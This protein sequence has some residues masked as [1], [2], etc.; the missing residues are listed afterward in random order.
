MTQASLHNTISSLPEPDEQ[1]MK[2]SS[3]LSDSIKSLIEKNSGSI[4][5][6]RYMQACLYEPGLGY[7]SA[8]SR[9]FGAAG[10]FITAPE[11]S[12]LFSR[13]LAA[14]CVQVLNDQSSGVILEVGAGSGRMACDILLEMEQQNILPEEYW[15][16]EVSADLIERQK[17][18]V[19]E[20]IPQHL[21]RIKW[22]DK[23]PIEKFNGIIL[24]N[25]VVD[26]LPIRRFNKV[27]NIF[28]ELK[29]KHYGDRFGWTSDQADK[30]LVSAIELL[31][32]KYGPWPENYYSEINLLLDG[33]VKSFSDIIKKGLM[34]IIDYG[35]PGSDYYHTEREDGTLLCHY[36][37]HAHSDPFLYPGLQDIS[38]SVN[39]TALAESADSNGL[40]VCGYTTQAYFLIACGL[41]KLIGDITSK[42]IKSQTEIGHQARKLTLPEEMGEKFKV[43]ALSKNYTS[44]LLGFSV[45]DQRVRL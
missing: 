15:I 38:S 30:E 5:F 26:A 10:D 29:V 2:L 9:K 27:N 35:Y 28:Y 24:A 41:E 3:L 22:L 32:E 33:W 6:D 23:L 11:L 17:Q 42:D 13:C 37:H 19:S 20:I 40:N 8:G 18:L 12:P 7:Y 1:A 16:L 44:P 45:M 36:R 25:E 4:G 34:L 21:N 31:E 39:F 14:Q 43:M